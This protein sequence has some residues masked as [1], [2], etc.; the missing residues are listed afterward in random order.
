MATV[1]RILR[2]RLH[3]ATPETYTLTRELVGMLHWE[4]SRWFRDIDPDFLPDRF[5]KLIFD[6]YPAELYG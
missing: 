3:A 1:A 5:E 6:D 4:F 2:N